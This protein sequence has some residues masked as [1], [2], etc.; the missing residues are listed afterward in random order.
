MP[1]WAWLGVGLIVGAV[2]AAAVLQLLT[3]VHL[4]GEINSLCH[5]VV[6]A[7]RR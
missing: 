5:V 4:Q 3:L 1:W 6:R 7:C 2:T